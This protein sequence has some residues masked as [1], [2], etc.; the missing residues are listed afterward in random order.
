MKSDFD[1][2][3]C[4]VELSR[5]LGD[6]ESAG[7]AQIEDLSSPADG[8]RQTMT[9][10]IALVGAR[11][12]GN[13]DCGFAESSHGRVGKMATIAGLF[14]EV[15][16]SAVPRNSNGP[17]QERAALIVFVKLTGH[18]DRNFLQEI[19]GPVEVVDSR[20]EV[21]KHRWTRL[22]PM[23]GKHCPAIVWIATRFAGTA[24]RFHG[25]AVKSAR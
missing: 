12:F 9:Q 15:E 21:S 18:G 23:A 8:F 17:G 2:V 4:G 13:A 16:Q 6:R 11:I 7:I 10:R 3:A 5:D 22:L 19:L 25:E 24:G 1:S 14:S 20:G